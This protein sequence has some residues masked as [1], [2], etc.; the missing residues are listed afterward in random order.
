MHPSA[1]ALYR[2]SLCESASPVRPR[3]HALSSWR[4]PDSSPSE[5]TEA[6]P[7]RC[8]RLNAPAPQCRG[9]ALSPDRAQRQRLQLFFGDTRKQRGLPKD[10]LASLIPAPSRL[11]LSSPCSLSARQDST[12]FP[13]VAARCDRACETVCRAHRN[14]ALSTRQLPTIAT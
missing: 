12:G 9:I 2:H 4:E 6:P 3:R 7:S 1:G 10:S 14:H 5:K 8:H 13:I 11:T